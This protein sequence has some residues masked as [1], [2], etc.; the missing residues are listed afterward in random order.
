M[1]VQYVYVHE[2]VLEC[3]KENERNKDKYNQYSSIFANLVVQQ[4]TPVTSSIKV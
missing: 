1:C 3:E 4:L 2:C